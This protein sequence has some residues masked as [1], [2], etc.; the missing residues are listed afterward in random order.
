MV[1]TWKG[2]LDSDGKKP[3][4]VRAPSSGGWEEPGPCPMASSKSDRPG[5]LSS[6]PS[7]LLLPLTLLF[8]LPR[9]RIQRHFEAFGAEWSPCVQSARSPRSPHSSV[10]RWGARRRHTQWWFL[11]C[12]F[13]CDLL[14][15]LLAGREGKC[16]S[17]LLTGEGRRWSSDWAGRNLQ[18]V[19]PVTL[20]FVAVLWHLPLT[21]C[22]V[23]R[24]HWKPLGNWGPLP[25]LSRL[26][27]SQ[28]PRAGQARPAGWF[29]SGLPFV[30]TPAGR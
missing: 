7:A 11:R 19:T 27:L 30:P 21:V 2:P 14:L 3:S 9:N 5:T 16:V 15:V 25:L 26:A 13:S 10:S 8:R 12:P 23:F 4:V 20:G 1:V 6:V 24:L 28:A 17:R 22:L 18:L 29:P